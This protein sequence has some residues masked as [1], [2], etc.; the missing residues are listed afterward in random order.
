MLR[1]FSIFALCFFMPWQAAGAD[2]LTVGINPEPPFIFQQGEVEWQGVSVYLWEEMAERL[3]TPYQYQPYDLQGLIAAIKKGRVDLAI[4]PMSITSQRL[5]AFNL[6]QPFYISDLT[7]AT[8]KKEQQT[9]LLFLRNFVSPDFL[10]AVALLFLILLVFGA[11]LWLS[12]RRSNPQMFGKGPRGIWDGIWWS[13]VTMTTVGYGDKV[14][15]SDRGKV[16]A[17]VWM[18]TAVIVTASFTA[19]IAS[20]LTVNTLATDLE[21]V[22]DLEN[23]ELG[24]VKGS[25]GEAFAREN[26]WPFKAFKTP[27]QAL[28]ALNNEQI[29]ALIYDK[30]IL[31]YLIKERQLGQSI[32]VLPWQLD[33]QYYAFSVPPD[34]QL[35]DRLNPLLFEEMEGP[36]WP[37]VLERYYLQ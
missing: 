37:G 7:V 6:T 14:P 17:V 32:E 25:S 30:P 28:K 19:G 5:K 27:A 2:T 13:A 20:S 34:S 10:Q 35:D 26:G 31:Q 36:A 11:L 24:I 15:V 22:A 16:I 4:T 9:L 23:A 1:Y 29:E 3:D 18:F 21:S 12:E 33:K 8:P